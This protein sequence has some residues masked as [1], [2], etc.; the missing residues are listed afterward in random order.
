[1]VDWHYLFVVEVCSSLV[2]GLNFV[3]EP[4]WF[5]D[6]DLSAA[7]QEWCEEVGCWTDLELEVGVAFFCGHLFL[8]VVERKVSHV[9]DFTTEGADAHWSEVEFIIADYAVAVFEPGCS[10]EVFR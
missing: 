4:F 7:G 9:E 6:F 2:L 5:E 3:G 8:A 10:I 1:M